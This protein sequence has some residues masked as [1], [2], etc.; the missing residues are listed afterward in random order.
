MEAERTMRKWFVGMVAVFVLASMALAQTPIADIQT[1]TDPANDDASPMVGQT[2]TVQGWVTFE[3]GSFGGKFFMADAAGPWNG[4]YVYG[5]SADLALGFGWE[6]EVTGTISEYF[7]MTELEIDADD[8]VTVLN[9][10][11]DWANLPAACDYTVVTAADIAGGAA[12]AEQ[13]ESVLIQIEDVTTA[14]EPDNFGEW[15]I[16]DVDGNAVAVD[17]PSDDV[18]GYFHNVTLDEPFT[19]VRGPL[20]YTYSAYK[21]LPEIAYDLRVAE[22]TANGWYTPISYFQQVRPMDMTVRYDDT[23][24]SYYT[25]DYSYASL[26]RVDQDL[27]T[28]NPDDYQYMVDNSQIVTIRGT[29]TMAPGMSYAGAGIKLIVDDSQGGATQ[30]W[31][32]VLSYNADS[33][34]FPSLFEGDQVVMTGFV[35]EYMT[36]PSNMTEL[37]ITAP[38][39]LSGAADVPVPATVTVPEMRNSIT[40][41]QWGNSFV[42]L[43]D[44]IVSNTDLAYEVMAV[45]NDMDDDIP[46]VQID[47][48]SNSNGSPAQ[49]EWQNYITPSV[50][51]VI[52]S[53]TGWVYNHYGTY[54]MTADDWA[55]KVEPLYPSWIVIG[56]GP[57]TIISV[58]RDIATPGADEAVEVTANVTDNSAVAGVSL[59]YKIGD[60]GDMQEVAMTHGDG[61]VWTGSIPGQA[62]GSLVWYYVEATDDIDQTST[63]PA[64]I[65]AN[66]YGYWATSDLGI[67]NVQYTP[68]PGGMSPY[69]NMLVTVSGTVTTTTANAN[70]Y[71]GSS[72]D[73]SDPPYFIQTGSDPE[74]SGVLVHIPAGTFDDDLVPGDNITVTGTVD[75]SGA[76]WSFKYSG[77]T[78]IYNVV[79]AT[80]DSQGN[81]YNMYDVT[82]A[83]VNANPEAYESVFVTFNNL[84]ITAVNSYDWTFTDDSGET[85]LLDDDIVGSGSSSIDTVA[86]NWYNSLEEGSTVD[87]VRGVVTWSFGSWKIEPRGAMDISAVYAPEEG[88]ESQPMAFEL[89]PAFP[90]P[91]NPSTTVAFTIPKAAPVQLIIYNELGQRVVKLIDDQLQAGQHT[92][93]WNGKDVSGNLVSSGVYYMRLISEGRQQ[94]QK[95]TLLK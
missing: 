91:F 30:P 3:P 72:S 94:V 48:D 31:S 34:A 17:N 43:Y 53:L 62:E 79:N 6:V 83:E 51:S 61:L 76:D 89:K 66:M 59:F 22:D 80:L 11:V 67:Y 81:N 20:N 70:Y 33:T 16:E 86:A 5:G 7:G 38:V 92:A 77:N 85:F 63:S 44:T 56:E 87:M 18:Y 57:P 42:R 73:L 15:S 60:D 29:V 82:A 13:Y 25:Y 69:A 64:N 78:R 32:A 4:I 40:A 12:T 27:D 28:N 52:D 47:D 14:T 74:F 55:Y 95:I 23:T 35:S 37:F 54:D 39:Q 49:E 93:F 9:D 45:D 90:N 8:A 2:V 24:E 10:Q 1:V 19:W 21:V 58:S 65:N 36:S 71:N 84:T 68:F 50:G 41:E 26:H 88:Y 75:E 46:G